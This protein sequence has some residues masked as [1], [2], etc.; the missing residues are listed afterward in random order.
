MENTNMKKLYNNLLLVYNDLIDKL[1]KEKLNKNQ[2]DTLIKETVKIMQRM[3][4]GIKILN[5]SDNEILNGFEIE[6]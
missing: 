5:P 1:E 2:Q 4:K 6:S 3:D